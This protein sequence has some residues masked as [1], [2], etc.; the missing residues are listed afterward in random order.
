MVTIVLVPGSGPKWPRKPYYTLRMAPLE[1]S[2][3]F[4][5]VL[6]NSLLKCFLWILL[7]FRQLNINNSSSSIGIYSR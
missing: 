3:V 6:I 5:N 4:A 2:Y 7:H 1:N